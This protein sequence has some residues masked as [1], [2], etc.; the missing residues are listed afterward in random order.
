MVSDI[1]GERR[2]PCPAVGFDSGRE[3]LIVEALADR[4]TVLDR[5]PGKTVWP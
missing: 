5:S 3:L 2:P 1:R 4:W